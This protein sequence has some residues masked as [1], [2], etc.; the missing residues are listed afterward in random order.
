V[1]WDTGI[2][3]RLAACLA[4]TQAV[5]WLLARGLGFRLGWRVIAAGLLLPLA[6]L[7][8]WLGDHRVLAPTDVLSGTLPLGPHLD[9]PDPHDLLND[10]VYQFLPWELEIRHALSA[11]RLP[12]WSDL[13]EGGSSPW[14]NPQAGVLSPLQ[15]PARLLPIQHH[16][17]AALALKILV[18][19]QGTWLL[20][21]RL[22]CRRPASAL[23]AAGFALGGGIMSWALFPHT[24]AAAWV[25]WLTVGVIGL[26]RHP[27]R[28]LV[29]ATAVLTAALLLSGHPE[30]AAIGG[31]FA[32]L[33]GLWLR[34][35]AAPFRKSF[36]AAALAAALGLA[37]AAPHVLP[38]LHVLPRSQRA[39]ETLALSLPDAPVRL[40][41]P[42]TWF[43]PGHG[44]FMLAPT[45]PH[46][47]GRPYRDAFQGPINWA[48]SGSGY[49][50]LIA[51][52]G[53][54]AAL[55]LCDRRARP[56]LAF[57][58]IGL[59]LAARF[60]PLAA[61][62]LAVPPLRA[63]AYSRFLLVT[64]LALAVAGAIGFDRLLRRD[65]VG[66][67]RAWLGIAG[68][69][70]AAA[71]SLL[72]RVDPHV[73]LLW[74]LIAAGA[75]AAV[76]LPRP[77]R[78]AP[79]VAAALLALALILDQV[80]WSRSLLPAGHPALFYPRTPFIDHLTREAAAPGGPYR[81]VGAEYLVYPS[82]L[83]VYGLAD[84]R[85]H[86]PLT[87]L[88]QIQVLDAAFG[89]SPSMV[90]YFARFGNVDH[91]LLD[92]LGVRAV[93]SSPAM[94]PSRTLERADDG[95]YAPFS[96]Y[97][98]PDAL[99]RW[100]LPA[101]AETVAAR[102]VPEWIARLDD[103]GKVALL[104][105][106]VG[107]WRPVGLTGQPR[108]V[109][110]VSAEPGHLV[111]RL[112]DSAGVEPTGETLLGTSLPG[113]AGWRATPGTPVTVNGAYLGVRLPAA[114]AEVELRYR[115]PGLLAGVLACLAAL[116]VC[117]WLAF[118]RPPSP[119]GPDGNA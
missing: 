55:A 95:R 78:W 84:P 8:P 83:S 22:G 60:L 45:S 48:D 27:R 76:L 88:V 98:N 68:V 67:R 63:L 18:A 23:A 104:S 62:T 33:C 47:F 37:L 7:L 24:A 110:T 97:R 79:R 82:V 61:L 90:D 53:A 113:P 41:E 94:P 15:I 10:A 91:P 5:C 31:L 3:L 11:G 46:A 87:A 30:T 16:L 111:L 56:F 39:H 52:A 100:F 50:G 66:G 9:D 96:L 32:T 72:V 92:F 81:M 99:P 119:E 13:L 118:S 42:L 101:A 29:A 86:N 6:F 51:L 43:L 25:P 21:R 54:F 2:L 35:R 70:A 64:S 57:A 93:V 71:V 28:R 116:A 1:S 103:G 107:A 102:Q 14:S 20:A 58:L 75:L 26:F 80:P 4:V 105:E 77:A 40:L 17:L 108:P 69:A 115:P 112:P 109:A 85:T 44:R 12:L 74:A 114:A 89:F 73:Q 38:F 34:R 106:E 65:R 36:G 117:A 59:L 49:A 19:F